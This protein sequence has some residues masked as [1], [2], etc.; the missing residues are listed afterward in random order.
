MYYKVFHNLTPWAPSDYFNIVI[1]PHNLHSVHHNFNIRKPL[2][3][4]N[5]FA[6]DFFNRRVSAWNSLSGLFYLY[7]RSVTYLIPHRRLDPGSQRPVFPGGY[8]SKYYNRGRRALT[9]VK[10][11]LR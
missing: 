11:P 5:I 1:S 3:R 7:G 9:S 2:G 10:V 4:T 8:P 6:K